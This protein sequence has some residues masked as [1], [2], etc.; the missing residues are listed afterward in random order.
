MKIGIGGSTPF[1]L[2]DLA[3][4]LTKACLSVNAGWH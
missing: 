1:T 4:P 3:L 2:S